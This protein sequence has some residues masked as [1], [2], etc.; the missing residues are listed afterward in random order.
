MPNKG[1]RQTSE[2]IKKAAEA[3]KG[4]LIGRS[5]PAYIVIDETVRERI[6]DLIYS[7]LSVS[8]ISKLLDLSKYIV[9]RIT[10]EEGEDIFNKLLINNRK[11]I[12]LSKLNDLNPMKKIENI[13]KR[14]QK[15][16]YKSI[17]KKV[18]QTR[19]KLF[20]EGKLKHWNKIYP[21]R[22]E[23]L[24]RKHQKRM[25]EDNPMFKSDVVKNV[26]EFSKRNGIYEKSRERM[27]LLWRN[28]D[29]RKKS[30]ERL[31]INNPM[32]RKDVII[33][34]WQNHQHKPTNIE[35]KI[36]KLIRIYN[37]P[38]EYVGNANFFIGYKNPDFKVI[39]QN[40]VIEVT[41]DAYGRN[42]DNYGKPI[43]NY[44]ETRG[45]DCLIIW[46]NCR[47]YKDELKNE[48]LTETL[49]K[50]KNFI[51]DRKEVKLNF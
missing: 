12:S 23:N 7:G 36:M 48:N 11:F 8:Q 21:L 45:Y 38:I 19:K 26:V 5:N 18:S 32:K 39:N 9:K 51:D 46:S 27:K 14:K 10:K 4:K 2:H 17:G 34:N 28:P 43:I 30:I 33:K 40:K 49:L 22:W 6:I 13:L 42:N 1:Y 15:I 37:L 20:R 47:R 25:R 29:F 24:L 50:I 3:R 31:K 41:S 16:D 44:Y 35:K